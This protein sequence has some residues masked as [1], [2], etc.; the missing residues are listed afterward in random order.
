MNWQQQA[1]K[2]QLDWLIV[3]ANHQGFKHHAWHM[4]NLMDKSE[5][6]LFQGIAQDLEKCMKKSSVEPVKAGG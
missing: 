4:A 3:M 1:Y 5:S 6:G 2:K